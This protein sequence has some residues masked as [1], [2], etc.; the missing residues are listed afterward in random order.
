MWY[1]KE[2]QPPP[3]NLEKDELKALKSL[4]MDRTIKILPA[5]KGNATVVMDAGQYEER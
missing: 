4:M 5:D 3:S 1:I 2:S